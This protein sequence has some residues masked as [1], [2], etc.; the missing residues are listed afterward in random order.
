M[1]NKQASDPSRETDR[2]AGR[3]LHSFNLAT[4]SGV[5]PGSRTQ[6]FQRVQVST[7]G[8][9]PARQAWIQVLWQQDERA[10]TVY[11]ATPGSNAMAAA[12]LF[13]LTISDPSTFWE[14]FTAALA[15]A[16]W[17]MQSCGNCHFWRKADDSAAVSTISTSS[18]TPI[19]MGNC[20]WRLMENTIPTRLKQQSSLALRCPHWQLIGK[21]STGAL[22]AA[23]DDL[24]TD[25]DTT[26]ESTPQQLPRSGESAAIRFNWRQRMARWLR[27]QWRNKI[28]RHQ[29]DPNATPPWQELL[30]ERSGVGA[31]TE[32]CFVCQ[33]R[34]ANLGALT[35]ATPE[36]D[37]ETLSVWR[38]RSCYTLYLNDWIDR[39]ERLDN[40]ETEE[41]YYRVTPAEALALLQIIYQEAGSEHP[42][43]RHER[44][45]Q[46][47]QILDFLATRTP[48]SHQIRQGR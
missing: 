7:I 3:P 10:C 17:Q 40:L 48:I 30:E 23:N 44:N 33:G 20:R 24:A 31:G 13:A 46:R 11:L 41:S 21:A 16:G 42:N 39:W 26:K 43:R 2:D 8:S 5:F 28:R 12:P 27:N 47:R 45:T 4:M 38:C 6:T 32:P 29:Q 15:Q 22:E 1:G 18:S 37:K 14:E 19:T 9:M 34:L 36:D 35:V 25:S